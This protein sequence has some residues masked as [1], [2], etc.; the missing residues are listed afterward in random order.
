[1]RIVVYGAGAVGGVV[2]ARLAQHGHEVVLV[3]RGEHRAA[4]ADA[5]LRLEAPSG[6]VTV[7]SPVVEGPHEIDWN[8]DEVVLLSVKSQNTEEILRRL[9]ASAPSSISVVCL[10]NGVDNERASLRHFA[11][12]YGVWVICP[13]G[14][15]EPGVVIAYS[16]PLTGVLDIGRYPL[17]SDQTAKAVAAAFES[18]TFESVV[19]PDIMRWKYTK[20]LMNLANAV[21]AVCGPEERDGELGRLVR[22]EGEACLHAAGIDFAS[23]DDDRARRSGRIKYSDDHGHQWPGSSS[24]QSLAR[25]TGTIEADYLN[26][27]IVLLGR[28]HGVPTPANELMQR[29]ANQVARQRARPGSLP[30]AQV[31]ALLERA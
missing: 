5:G 30:A 29:L 14:H 4:I 19:R 24:W 17:G 28:L 23:A 12:V 22:E 21:D 18:S 15:F 7:R 20:L 13:A 1:V 11:N 8:G 9:I 16:S 27:E 3:A 31:L 6:P 25:S 26:G 2:G 10:Q